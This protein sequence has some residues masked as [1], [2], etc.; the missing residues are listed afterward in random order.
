MWIT[1]SIIFAIAGILVLV[2]RYLEIPADQRPSF[3]KWLRRKR[4]N[5]QCSYKP[6]ETAK[7]FAEQWKCHPTLSQRQAD[8]IKRS[9][10]KKKR[11]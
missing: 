7:R 11:G 8:A 6:D 1:F 9:L 2:T 10:R 3:L 4:F 5:E